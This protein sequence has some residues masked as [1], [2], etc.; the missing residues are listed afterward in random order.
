MADPLAAG[1][2][3]LGTVADR[4]KLDALRMVAEDAAGNPAAVRRVAG[5]LIGKLAA[6]PPP[7][8][9]PVMYL[10]DYI[11]KTLR[12][13]F[14]EA[15]APYITKAFV[16]AFYQVRSLHG[17]AAELGSCVVQGHRR[18][19]TA[20]SLPPLL[21]L[22]PIVGIA[23]RPGAAAPRAEHVARAAHFHCSRGCHCLAGAARR[24]RRGASS[25]RPRRPRIRHCNP[26]SAARQA[27]EA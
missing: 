1:I 12:P 19:L 16:D 13:E 25:R 21:Q 6:L 5:T 2:D 18:R 8:K 26:T 15:L 7:R 27:P 20:A 17:V 23:R 14:Q 22:T 10:I 3:D 4:V 9:I 24:R 11:V